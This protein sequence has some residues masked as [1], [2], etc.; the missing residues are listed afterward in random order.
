[1]YNIHDIFT[2]FPTG[3]EVN[4]LDDDVDDDVGDNVGDDVGDEVGDDT[5]NLRST[6]ELFF[7]VIDKE[8]E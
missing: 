4:L 3:G 5:D 8:N 6:G 2:S 1:M 7:S